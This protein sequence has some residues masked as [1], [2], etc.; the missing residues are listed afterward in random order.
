MTDLSDL[1]DDGPSPELVERALNREGRPGRP[2][3]EEQAIRDDAL[4][5]AKLPSV[6]TLVRPVSV[7]TLMTVFRKDRNYVKKC[8]ASLP[9]VGFEGHNRPVYDFLQ[10]AHRLIQPEVDIAKILENISEDDIPVHLQDKYWGGQ[11]KR[12]KWRRE[13]GQLWHTDDVQS[14]F[15][16]VFMLMKSSIQLW[17]STINEA[18][19]LSIE[20]R[21]VLQRLC[22]QL[23]DDLRLRL[24]ELPKLRQTPSLAATEDAL[25]EG[26]KKAAES[27]AA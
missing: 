23:L 24:V 10:C 27:E 18:D 16:D 8:L 4:L 5:K 6:D 3:A 26:T 15:G 20:Q 2:S 22:D 17:S 12:T 19:A 14:V 9:P 13:A 25:I 7:A 1:F 21:E 11:L